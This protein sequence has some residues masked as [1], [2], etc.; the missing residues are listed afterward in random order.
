MEQYNSRYDIQGFVDELGI[1]SEQAASLYKEF[2][3]E[4]ELQLS[5]IKAHFIAEDYK[6][7]QASIH[8]VK[9]VSS[10]FRIEDL[11]NLA[12]DINYNLKDED[13]TNLDTYIQVLVKVIEATQTEIRRTFGE[14]GFQ[15]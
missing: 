12:T 8:N 14:L 2:I 7:L 6:K 11:Y 9:G 10:N 13:Y 4:L 15:L 5:E 1:D 3:H